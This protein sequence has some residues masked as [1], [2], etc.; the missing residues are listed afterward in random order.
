M[1]P[2]PRTG[3]GSHWASRCRGRQGPAWSSSSTAM[4]PGPGSHILSLAWAEHRD[5]VPQLEGGAWGQRAVAAPG[6]QACCGLL[7]E[8]ASP[9]PAQEWGPGLDRPLL[10]CALPWRAPGVAHTSL[11]PLPPPPAQGPWRVQAVTGLTAV[12]GAR[13]ALGRSTCRARELPPGLSTAC[14]AA[15]QPSPH[16]CA[17]C[18]LSVC[19]Q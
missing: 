12:R 13:W 3:P 16:L 2:T 5:T 1:P 15:G 14:C 6:S 11:S 8:P 18:V 17:S 10:P 7:R 4:R 19:M 9:G